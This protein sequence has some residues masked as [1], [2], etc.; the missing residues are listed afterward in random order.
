MRTLQLCYKHI[1][2]HDQT[3]KLS[4]QYFQLTGEQW[5]GKKLNILKGIS[6]LAEFYRTEKVPE[7]GPAI[8]VRF[9]GTHLLTNQGKLFTDS[10]LIKSYLFVAVKEMYQE[11]INSLKTL[12][13]LVKTVADRVEGIGSNIDS[14][15]KKQERWLQW[16]SLALDE[17]TDVSNAPQLFIRGVGAEMTESQALGIVR[18]EE[19]PSSCIEINQGD[20][21]KT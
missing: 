19:G 7:D 9:W 14:Q 4:S 5:S 21:W 2:R 3:T 15:L 18:E 17:S 12:S 13:L 16:F 1:H 20:L 11:K 8:R 6:R 10:K